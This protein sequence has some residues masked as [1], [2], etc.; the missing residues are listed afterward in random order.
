MTEANNPR[1]IWNQC[2][3]LEKTKPAFTINSSTEQI[4]LFFIGFIMEVLKIQLQ[5]D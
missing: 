2:L 3:S 1:V 4:F 5:A